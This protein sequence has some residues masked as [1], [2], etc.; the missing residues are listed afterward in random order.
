MKLKKITTLALL[1]IAS[2]LIS[3]GY[4]SNVFTKP[5]ET[6]LSF[7]KGDSYEKLWKRVDS[8]EAKGLTESALKIVNGIY[9]KAKLDNNAPQFVKAILHRMKFESYKEEFSLEKSIFK[10][11][12]EANE[13]KYPIKPVLQSVL[14]D[15]FWQYFQ[16]NRWKFYNRTSTV[17]FK[18]DDIETWD[19]KSITNAIIVNYKASLENSDSLKRTK[20]DIYDAIINKGTTECRVW[21]PTLYDFLAHRALG[22]L[23]NTEVEVTRP[24]NFYF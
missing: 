21:R 9:T 19:L 15:A 1:C 16:N 14:A 11:R 13:A 6:Q 22:Y 10:L 3:L 12:D 7:N 5:S 24:A 4:F 23:M 17:N 20:I 2:T 18:N 8:C